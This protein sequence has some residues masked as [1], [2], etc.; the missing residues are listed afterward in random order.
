MLPPSSSAAGL[1]I[2][3]GWLF[4]WPIVH[5][6][7]S[8]IRALILFDMSESMT[9]PG[10][11][12]VASLHERWLGE[13]QRSLRDVAA[14]LAPGDRICVGTFASQI[15][16]EADC[17]RVRTAS[18]LAEAVAV[19]D[20]RGAPS[21]ISDAVR[22]GAER[23]FITRSPEFLDAII[24]VTDGLN[25]GNSHS[26]GSTAS[27]AKRNGV[28][29]HAIMTL[30]AVWATSDGPTKG[31]AFELLRGLAEAAGGHAE[32]CGRK[33]S[34]EDCSTPRA[35]IGSLILQAIEETRKR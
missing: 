6:A 2:L 30:P 17:L 22:L 18:Q 24:V 20:Q 4:L 15:R 29:V 3:A 12:L 28:A 32:E 19:L 16:I 21:P 14:H 31:R 7:P 26:I 10:P 35:G 27:Y 5:A 25:S 33:N 9:A 13:T 8:G 1:A 11:A 23:L 34:G